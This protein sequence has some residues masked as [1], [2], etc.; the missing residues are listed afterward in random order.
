MTHTP[1]AHC[2]AASVCAL[3]LCF[4]SP[5]PAQDP[6][7]VPW[8]EVTR[9]DRS[10]IVNIP[11]PGHL[12]EWTYPPLPR[13]DVK[14][15]LPKNTKTM[16]TAAPAANIMVALTVDRTTDGRWPIRNH[17][18]LLRAHRVQLSTGRW[19]RPVTLSERRW[20]TD[21]RPTSNTTS[22]P[23]R[24]FDLLNDSLMSVSPTG[25]RVLVKTTGNGRLDMWSIKNRAHHIAAWYPYAANNTTNAPALLWAAILND[26]HV[27]TLSRR[28]ELI[29]WRMPDCA[30]VWRINLAPK[31]PNPDRIPRAVVSRPRLS[32]TQKHLAVWANQ[33]VSIIDS[34]TGHTRATIPCN[35]SPG[36]M[37]PSF[38]PDGA[39]LAITENW[40]SIQIL[41]LYDL[42]TGEQRLSTPLPPDMFKNAAALKDQ[43]AGFN[44]LRDNLGLING[45]L[46][47]DRRFGRP[48]K[49]YQ[50]TD[51]S[52][53]HSAYNPAPYQTNG[54]VFWRVKRDN[55]LTLIGQYLPGDT[56]PLQP[57]DEVD[58]YAA[59]P[60]STV[61]LKMDLNTDRHIVQS[62]ERTARQTLA[63]LHMTEA[64]DQ[65][66][67]LRVSAAIRD[68]EESARLE[69][70][71]NADEM[72][73]LDVKEI[74]IEI[75]WVI[76]GTV[77]WS[78]KRGYTMGNELQVPNDP[79]IP[80]RQRMLAAQWKR[81]A[82][83][84]EHQFNKVPGRV[85]DPEKLAL[86]PRGPFPGPKLRSP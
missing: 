31:E 24:R 40:D 15:S 56:E 6:T 5:A 54:H 75:A 55:P 71:A 53:V 10:Q 62:F 72:G 59:K 63:A 58:W 84:A 48:I 65:P 20:E 37:P 35:G 70:A 74:Q 36:L 3:A 7:D 73:W 21:A 34:E 77:I 18:E 11:R 60:G 57:A 76:R 22:I 69:W 61:I 26:T 41:S 68:S 28:G 32:P 83:L 64:P 4:T 80:L 45:R 81:A 86:I 78:D 38:S 19:Y 1:R 43:Y 52:R 12:I 30:A 8:P 25:D 17:T 39:Q 14:I 49:Q 46:L 50:V 42:T 66:M 51:T 79:A 44:W 67:V 47:I 85:V 82:S 2:V 23:A 13:G 9:P 33:T 16:M 27:L 29:Q